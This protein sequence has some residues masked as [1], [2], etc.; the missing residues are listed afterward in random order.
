MK[1]YQLLLLF[2]ALISGALALTA[3]EESVLQTFRTSWPALSF[4]QP[5]WTENISEA[6]GPRPFYGLTCSEGPDPHVTKMYGAVFQFL[7]SSGCFAL[8]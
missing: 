4:I 8:D 1:R 7:P 3:G 5:V 2:A 6:C